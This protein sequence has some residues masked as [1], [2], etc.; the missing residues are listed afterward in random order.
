MIHGLVIGEIWSTIK[1]DSL[2]GRKMLVVAPERLAS[3]DA[4]GATQ[5]VAVDCVHAGVGDRVIVALGKAAR[6]AVGDECAACEAAI[7]GVVDGVDLIEAETPNAPSKKK[8]PRKK[9]KPSS[10]KKVAAP[11]T[12]DPE[13]SEETG[14][15][16][17]AVESQEELTGPPPEDAL[18]E[19]TLELIPEESELTPQ[20][21]ESE[22]DLPGFDNVDD[23]W[24]EDEEE[25]GD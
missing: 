11:P 8:A 3:F 20:S 12:P 21:D 25:K 15:L 13:P 4:L 22:P 2:V 1:V 24:N 23:V 9:K 17:A 7:V 16:F 6:N 18:V 14:D 5:I 19:E 10:K